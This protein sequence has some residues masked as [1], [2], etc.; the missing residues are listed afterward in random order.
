MPPSVRKALN[1]AQSQEG[2]IDYFRQSNRKVQSYRHLLPDLDEHSESDSEG[3]EQYDPN[4]LDD[5]ELR[6]GKH[7][8]VIALTS[9]LGSINHFT[10]AEFLKRE[11][12]EKF[13]KSHPDVH[14]S[15][16]LSQ[17]RNLKMRLLNISSEEGLELAT[18]ARAFT[19]LEKLILARAVHKANRKVVGGCCLIL[20]AKATDSK[21][22]DY[23]RLLD[24]MAAVLPVDR[25]EL[26]ELEFGVL[27]A[28]HFKLQISEREYG[29]HLM[30]ILYQLDYSN[31]QEYLGERMHDNWQSHTAS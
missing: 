30:R 25:R 21:A 29:A 9:F 18:V 27:A 7:R 1:L 28:L 14:P 10:K 3:E 16:T 12:N 23:A 5:P 2:I 22:T 24:R 11:L 15:L 13:R 31:L 4:F 6:T 20:A 19:Y 26:V 8:T 17:I